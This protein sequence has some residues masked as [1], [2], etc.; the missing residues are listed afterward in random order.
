MNISQFTFYLLVSCS[1]IVHAILLFLVAP[2]VSQ[3]HSLK[4]QESYFA[5]SFNFCELLLLIPSLESHI[6]EG[7]SGRLAPNDDWQ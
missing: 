7:K 2:F 6:I 1:K 3:V 5:Y 4:N